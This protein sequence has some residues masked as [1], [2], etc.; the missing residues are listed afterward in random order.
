MNT[1]KK[2]NYTGKDINL[3]IKLP[4][5]KSISNRALILN[6]LSYSPFDV[7][8]LSDCDDTRVMVAAFDSNISSF[9]VG[10]AGTSMRFLTAFLSKTVGEW[11]ITGS[12]RM[13]QRPIRILVDALNK[14]G[15]KVEY[16]ENDG[17][18]PLKIYGSA[19]MG[20]EIDLDGSISSQY[21]SA[22]MMIAPYMVNGL[23]INLKSKVISKPYIQMT[24]GMMQSF[25]VKA[26]FKDDKIDIR[27]QNYIPTR[28]RVESD[29]SAASYWYEILALSGKGN[30]K[31]IGLNENSL[32]GDRAVADIFENLGVETVFYENEVELSVSDQIRKVSDKFRYDFTNVPDLAQTVVVTCCLMKKPFHFSGLQSLKIKE[33]NRV[34]A[35]MYE[36]RKLGYVLVEPQEGE[37]MW[38]GTCCQAD[39]IATIDTYEDH[40]MAMAFAPIALTHPLIIR[41]PEV[42]SKSYPLFW[43]DMSHIISDIL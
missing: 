15:G 33:T 19:M 9:D 1:E 30:I 39:E 6:A 16:L 11:T 25:G 40:R 42:V 35:L 36:L 3:R 8:N 5:S 27:P 43:N 20:G 14:L 18:P 2:L 10:A 13:K 37:L 21:I 31:L 26:E 41:N 29:W 24:L 28:Y 23:T 32:Q 17:Y 7:E 34:A 12:E 38:D 22:L 4:A